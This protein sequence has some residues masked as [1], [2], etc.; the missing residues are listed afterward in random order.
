LGYQ[1]QREAPCMRAIHRAQAIRIKWGVSA[2]LHEPFPWKP[3]GMRLS[4]YQRLRREILADGV[5]G[6]STT[7]VKMFLKAGW[8]VSRCLSSTSGS[9][10]VGWQRPHNGAPS[11]RLWNE[12]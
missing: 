12:L 4:T 3:E 2:N 1:R 7:T 8:C 6:L 10:P 9:F 5:T 11:T